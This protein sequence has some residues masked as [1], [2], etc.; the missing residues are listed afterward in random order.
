[1]AYTDSGIWGA[2]WLTAS[3]PAASW[4]SSPVNPMRSTPPSHALPG[5]N[6]SE[7]PAANHSMLTSAATATTLA[8]VFSTFF[9]RTMPA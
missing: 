3:L 8:M 1:M 9:L 6:A 2:T 5:V 4:K 7:Y